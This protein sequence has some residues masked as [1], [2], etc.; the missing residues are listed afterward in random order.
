M[1]RR[2][3]LARTAAFFLAPLFSLAFVFAFAFAFAFGTES[4]ILSSC[5]VYWLQQRPVLSGGSL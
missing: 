5:N 2:A 1:G 3:A 4:A